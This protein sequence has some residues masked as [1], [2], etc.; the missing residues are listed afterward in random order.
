MNMCVCAA[1]YD[2]ESRRP[3][4]ADGRWCGCRGC[5]AD[6]RPQTTLFISSMW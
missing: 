3:V 2:N 4:P 1:V 6:T 5:V